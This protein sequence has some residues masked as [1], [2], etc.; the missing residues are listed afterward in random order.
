LSLSFF[1]AALAWLCTKG[2]LGLLPFSTA[3]QQFLV[4]ASPIRFWLLL[5]LCAFLAVISMLWYDFADRERA[6]RRKN[7]TAQL[8][9]EAELMQLRQQ[10]QPH[11]LFNSLNSVNALIGSRPQEARQMI[12]QLSSFLRNTVRR[13]EDQWISFAEELEHLQLYLSIEEV[14]FGNRLKIEFDIE[15]AALDWPVPA[16]LLQPLVENAIKFGLY[17]TLGETTIVVRAKVLDG[18]LTLTV[19]NPFDADSAPAEKGTG[20]GLNGV[21]RRVELLFGRIDLVKVAITNNYFIV[22]L[23]IPQKKL[24]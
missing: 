4:S 5:L 9:K 12:Q 13:K 24:A 8:A 11:F 17:G 16:L 3:Y 23:N 2:L 1:V 18:L 20:F 19:E 6:A 14:R 7:E 15:D 22:V 10:L 21:K